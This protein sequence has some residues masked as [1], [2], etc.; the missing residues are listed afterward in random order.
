M[1]KKT[2][3]LTLATW[4]SVNACDCIP[5]QA[6]EKDSGKI[7]KEQEKP[8]EEEISLDT[9]Y[10]LGVSVAVSGNANGSFSNPKA[11]VANKN[12]EEYTITGNRKDLLLYAERGD[13]IVVRVFMKPEA[14]GWGPKTGTIYEMRKTYETVENL[15]ANRLKEKWLKQINNKR[16]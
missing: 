12:G 3:L 15:T 10:V 16:R 7:K 9:V 6:P 13:E 5:S 4:L 14:M 8:A 11:R 1:T 2:L